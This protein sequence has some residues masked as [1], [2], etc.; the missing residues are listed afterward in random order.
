MSKSQEER[1]KELLDKYTKF[2][3]QKPEEKI[4]IVRLCGILSYLEAMQEQNLTVISGIEQLEK[5]LN[6]LIQPYVGGDDTNGK[7][8]TEGRV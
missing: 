4:K 3:H 2:I 1:M 7:E 6:K 8:E 5:F